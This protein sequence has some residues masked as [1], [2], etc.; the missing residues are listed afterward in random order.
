MSVDLGD[1]DVDRMLV[2]ETIVGLCV[3]QD[4]RF[5]HANRAFAE[6]L[7]YTVPEL[8]GLSSATHIAHVDERAKVAASIRLC[9]PDAYGHLSSS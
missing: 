7:G 3:I 9:A 4:D 1:A 2:E 6:I 8:L 5:V